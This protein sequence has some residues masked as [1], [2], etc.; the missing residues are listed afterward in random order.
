MSRG[1]EMKATRA[2]ALAEIDAWE[3][4]FRNAHEELLREY[5]D[6]HLVEQE[7]ATVDRLATSC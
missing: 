7:R 1:A 4:W 6:R 5:P 3:R 2:A